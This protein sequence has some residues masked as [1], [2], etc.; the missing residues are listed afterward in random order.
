MFVLATLMTLIQQVSGT[1]YVRGGDSPAG[2]DCSG[3]VS[4][5]AN[6]ATDRPVF[7]SRFNTGNEEAALLARGFQYGTAPGALVIGWNSHHT[8][9]T[10][11]DG[12][13]VSSGEGGGVRIGGGGAYQP[14]FTHHM[15]LPV[16][17]AA[18]ED[19]PPPAEGFVLA[20]AVAPEPPAPEPPAPEAD[21]A[22]AEPVDAEAPA[23]QDD[24]APADE[25]AGMQPGME[26]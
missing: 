23:P 15:F 13:P 17:P 18:M 3:L 6:A 20:D 8:A 26:V 4:W 12:T 2:T 10:L 7:G 19:A 5:V 14:Q 16:D 25:P 11:P 21:P 22:P 1:P 24:P 9:A